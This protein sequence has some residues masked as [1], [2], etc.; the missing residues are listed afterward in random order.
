MRSTLGRSLAPFAVGLAVYCVPTPAGLSPQAWLY[1]ALFL[2]VVAGLIL[3]PVPAAL[4][5][6]IGVVAACLLGVGPAVKDKAVTNGDLVNWGLSGFS[7]STVWLIFAAFM[8]AMGYEKS[9]LGKRIALLL[10]KRLGKS[11]LGLGYAVVFA[12]AVLAPFM[13]SNTARSAGTIFPIVRNIPVMYDSLPDKEP[14]K[15][16]AYLVWVALAGTC[17]TSSLFMTGLATNVLAVSIMRQNGFGVEWLQWFK[18]FAPV[19]V[20][21]LL[22]VPLLTYVLYPPTMKRSEETP[23]WAAA[24]LA[25]MGPLRRQEVVM[26]L[27]A[28]LAL[29][30]WIFGEKALPDMLKTGFGVVYPGINATTAAL[31]VL[32]AMV[33]TGVVTWNDII[34]NKQAWNVLAWFGT[35]VALAGGLA[36]VGF[37]KWFAGFST[38]LLQGFGPGTVAVGLVVLFFFAHYFF[39]SS[40]AHAAALLALFLTTAKGIPGLNQ[41]QTALLLCLTFGIMGI[42]TPYGTGPSPIWYGTGYVKAGEFWL[43]GA[44]FGLLFLGAFLFVCVPWIAFIGLGG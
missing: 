3:E 42:I 8:F 14:R 24:Q 43:L 27:L 34:S 23:R 6:V 30:L 29:V 1:F 35:L 17:V 16:G 44:V 4:V 13:P 5:G 12:D 32:V 28:V 38:S 36:N 33:L 11:S 19:G 22:A 41:G 2:A 25:E 40:T 37:L 10:V 31:L 20:P 18:A 9:G 7:Q 15:L 21:L 39:A 26:A